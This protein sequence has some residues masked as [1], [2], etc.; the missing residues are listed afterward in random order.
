MNVAK[1]PL[2][3]RPNIGEAPKNV[4]VVPGVVPGVQSDVHCRVALYGYI[5]VPPPR[6]EILSILALAEVWIANRIVARMAYRAVNW[7]GVK[8]PNECRVCRK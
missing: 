3:S 1:V 7:A 8:V 5:P 2:T 6:L 4:G